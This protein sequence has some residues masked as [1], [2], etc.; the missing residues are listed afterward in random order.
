[1]VVITVKAAILVYR[2]L[3][4]ISFQFVGKGQGSFVLNLHQDLVDLGS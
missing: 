3:I 1:M 4:R 2:P